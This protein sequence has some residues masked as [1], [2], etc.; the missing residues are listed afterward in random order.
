MIEMRRGSLSIKQRD[1]MDY[2]DFTHFLKKNKK[3]D[4]TIARHVAYVKTFET[5]LREKK[6]G[7]RLEE[8][9][10]ADAADFALWGDTELQGV[11]QYIW[12]I[13]SFAEYRSHHELE[14]TSNV[15]LGERYA[16]QFKLKD[17]EG[18]S[19]EHVNKLASLGIETAPQMI[20]AGGT[21]EKREKLSQD[22]DIP[23]ESVIKLVK[24]SDLSRIP[25]LK[26]IRARLYS[27]AGLDTIEKIS[28][29]DPEEMRSMLREFIKKSGFPG[30]APLL[31]EAATTVETAKHLPRRVSY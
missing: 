31:K 3:S 4:K 10:P 19:P 9:T 7:K 11:T 1:V 15:L 16:S 21:R 20:A 12:A 25:G 27:E 8:A 26:K 28:L 29:W 24:L 30:S 14:V 18:I 23:I 17:F 2:D 13:K 6:H 5:Y 22:L